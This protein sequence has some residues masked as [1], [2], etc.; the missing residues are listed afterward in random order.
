MRI[1]IDL[2]NSPHVPFFNAL[3]K[4]IA[5]RGNEILI[6]ARD[7]A[8]TVELAA[9]TGLKAETIGAYGGRALSRKAGNLLQRARALKRWARD[10]SLDLALSHN[11]YS[12]LVAAR[13][14][15]LRSVTLM[16]YEFQPANHLAF[17]LA[18]RVIVPAAFPT[19][20]LRKFGAHS[21][22]VCR[23]D[24]TKED[25]YL[26]D[27]QPDPDFRERLNA[28][29]VGIED[30]LVVMRPPARDALYHRFENDLFTEL[31]EW[32][33][34]QPGVRIIL[35]ARNASQQQA[36]AGC[37]GTRVILPQQPLDGANLIAAS[38]L[39]VSAGGTM[40]REAAA[41]GVPAITTFAGKWA[42]IDEQLVRENRLVKVTSLEDV[43]KVTIRKKL[44]PDPRRAVKVKAQ[45]V[46]L[47]LGPM[48]GSSNH[49]V[50]S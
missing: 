17:R 40:N 9:L 28:L 29:G 32:I 31:F 12:Q 36:Y 19:D 13:M 50:V 35:L 2:A 48:T 23:Y 15:G 21:E 49:P 16:D 10:L 11:S 6:T 38:D 1:W 44:A 14:L 43:E 22:K 45:V 41:L 34:S 33:C 4:P 46:D 30:V 8:E 26:A 5:E 37:A 27:F 20:S 24:G 3:L 47:I 42:A 39:V 25:V 7:F 18:T